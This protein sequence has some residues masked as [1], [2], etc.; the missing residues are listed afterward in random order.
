MNEAKFMTIARGLMGRSLQRCIFAFGLA[1]VAA[2]PVK[3]AV[4]NPKVVTD[5]SVDCTSRE[6]IIRDIIK[7]DMTDEEKAVA[8]WR[9]VRSRIYHYDHVDRSALR[10]LN[11][12]GYGLCGTQANLTEWILK[13]LFGDQHTHASGP[14]GHAGTYAEKKRLGLGWLIAC[15]EGGMKNDPGGGDYG[16]TM[17]EVFYDRRWHYLD[18]HAG[19]YVYTGDG[20]IAGVDEIKSDPTLV[21]WPFKKSAPFMP[22]DH[23]D[24]LYFYKCTGGGGT[25]W[26]GPIWAGSTM[27]FDLRRGDTFTRLFDKIPGKYVEVGTSPSNFPRPDLVE[28]PRHVCPDLKEASWRHWGN[29]VLE[30]VPDLTTDALTDGLVASSNVAFDPLKGPALRAADPAKPMSFTLRTTLPYA[31]IDFSIDATVWSA[32]GAPV[33]VALGPKAEKALWRATGGG[34]QALRLADVKI[35]G[36]Y[37]YDLTF[38]F[39]PG[40]AGERVGLDSLRVKTVCQLNYFALPR[41]VPGKNRVTVTFDSK[42][43]SK[44]RLKVTWAWNEA[45]GE[46]SDSRLV[47]K[48]GEAYDLSVGTTLTEPPEN[49]K[50]VKFIRMEVLP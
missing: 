16:H 12:Y 28:G 21:S 6:T 40:Q 13:G 4:F 29:G 48:S 37:T 27:D 17:Y 19:F 20:A 14:S 24:G 10:Q 25:A 15:W 33:T 3:A 23:G 34:E 45:A 42:A 50:Y 43:G 8:V 35:V 9:F 7:P 1:V 2:A 41:L 39:S 22:C 30:Y 36:Q 5:T 38:T 49:P 31:L 46:Q 26:G 32:A 11:V 44:G 47:E 18:P